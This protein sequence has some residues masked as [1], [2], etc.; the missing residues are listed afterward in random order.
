M[1]KID[2]PDCRWNLTD[3]HRIYCD[4]CEEESYKRFKL[5]W[6]KRDESKEALKKEKLKIIKGIKKGIEYVDMIPMQIRIKKDI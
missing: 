6:K 5:M 1:I 3:D 4:R 2:C